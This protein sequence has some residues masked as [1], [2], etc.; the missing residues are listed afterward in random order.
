MDTVY[1]EGL[2]VETVIGVFDWERKIKQRL[3]IDLEMAWDCSEAG[4]SDELDDALDYASVSQAITEFVEASSYQLIES[5]ADGICALVLRDF[6]VPQ[7]TVKVSK[8]GAVPT[9]ANVAV[10]ITRATH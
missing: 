4:R 5:V 8:P 1:V 2:A 6:N 9:A 7:V 3:V 10:K